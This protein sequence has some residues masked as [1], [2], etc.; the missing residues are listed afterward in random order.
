MVRGL[1]SF[2]KWFDILLDDCYYDYMKSGIRIA[3]EL[4][5]LDAVRLIPFEAKAWLDLS[6]RKA[7]GGQVD[8]KHIKKHKNDILTLSSLLQPDNRI[9]L[10]ENVRE[11]LANFMAANSEDAAKLA[12]VALIYGIKGENIHE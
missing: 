10:P 6:E 1:D 4:P 12:R 2:K 9:K 7:K 5:I 8:S 3:D 11:D